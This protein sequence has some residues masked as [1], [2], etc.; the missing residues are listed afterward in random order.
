MIKCLRANTPGEE[1]AK[2]YRVGI[3]P[4]TVTSGWLEGKYTNTNTDRV[5]VGTGSVLVL[6]RRIGLALFLFI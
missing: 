5:P 4:S 6:V 3:R 1:Q 2:R